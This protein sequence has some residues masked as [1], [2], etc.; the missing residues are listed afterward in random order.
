MAIAST[1]P[2]STVKR[3]MLQNK[4]NKQEP[5]LKELYLN[6]FAELKKPCYIYELKAFKKLDNFRFVIADTKFSNREYVSNMYDELV[7]NGVVLDEFK[8]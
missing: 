7:R 1:L 8:F 5:Y 4:L 6:A 2:K 3:G